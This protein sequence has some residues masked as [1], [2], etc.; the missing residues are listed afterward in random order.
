MATEARP[1]AERKCQMSGAITR[2]SE[3]DEGIDSRWHGTVVIKV[4]E[5]DA[6]LVEQLGLG[7]RKKLVGDAQLE[8]VQRRPLQMDSAR[9]AATLISNAVERAGEKDRLGTQVEME[10]TTRSHTNRWTL[11]RW[12]IFIRA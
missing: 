8:E 3:N 2:V 7:G 6:G 1:T 11:S 12:S 9:H 5:E 4:V 10:T